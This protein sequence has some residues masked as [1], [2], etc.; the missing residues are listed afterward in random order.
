M[1]KVI[2]SFLAGMVMATSIS[3]YADEGL[4]KIEAYLR[5]SL[6]ITLDGKPVALENA[7]VMYDGSTYL[8]LRDAAKLTGTD[9]NWNEATQTVELKS[10]GTVATDTKTSQAAGSG[11]SVPVTQQSKEE[12]LKIL[13][14]QIAELTIAIGAIN[15]SLE[16]AKLNLERDP[17]NVTI[18]NNI[19]VQKSQITDYEHQKATAEAEKAA[20]MAQP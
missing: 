2:V 20:L 4:A 13:N 17:S 5:P 12:K 19:N 18:Q 9:V 3:V 1:K 15:R 16:L 10:A 6:A 8:K 7:P 14:S 11:V